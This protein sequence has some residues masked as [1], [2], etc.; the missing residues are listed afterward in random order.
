MLRSPKKK[1]LFIFDNY[2]FFIEILLLTL[3]NQVDSCLLKRIKNSKLN[4][5]LLQK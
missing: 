2:L 1:V 3:V 5:H 4:S